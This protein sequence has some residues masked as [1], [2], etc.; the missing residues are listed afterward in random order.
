[1]SGLEAYDAVLTQTRQ[2]NSIDNFNN[3]HVISAPSIN[4][5]SRKRPLENPI[6]RE[7]KRVKY[8]H[9]YDENDAISSDL[10]SLSKDPTKSTQKTIA[11]AFSSSSV[12]PSKD[13]T[14]SILRQILARLE[15]LRQQHKQTEREIQYIIDES[16]SQPDLFIIQQA[17]LS[18]TETENNATMS[19]ELMVN[20]RAIT[21]LLRRE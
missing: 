13:S 16:K 20:L 2:K 17:Q 12:T 6:E 21:N 14:D 5:R 9:T 19:G 8:S 15:L 11:E 4:T 7:A 18:Q 1:M 10:L 3:T